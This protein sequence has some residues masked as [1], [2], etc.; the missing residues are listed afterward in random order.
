MKRKQV[1]MR[2]EVMSG[3]ERYCYRSLFEPGKVHHGIARVYPEGLTV[4]SVA[5]LAEFH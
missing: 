2:E 5:I 1:F 3:V 4:L